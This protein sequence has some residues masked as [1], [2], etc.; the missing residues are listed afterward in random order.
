MDGRVKRGQGTV[1]E[2]FRGSEREGGQI[3]QR[4]RG[5]R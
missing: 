5:G 1:G 3:K 2:H 4:G